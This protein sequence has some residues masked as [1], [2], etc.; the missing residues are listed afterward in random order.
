MPDATL[1]TRSPLDLDR[2]TMRRLGHLVADAVAEPLATL[3]G[4]PTRTPPPRREAEGLVAGPAPE[5]G[6]AFE[7]L[8]DA[9]KRDVFAYHAREPH[10]GFMAYVPSCPT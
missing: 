3:R 8:L 9:L 6:T 7:T 1:P 2:D 4:Q 5:E 10:P